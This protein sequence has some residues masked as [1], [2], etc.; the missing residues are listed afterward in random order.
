MERSAVRSLIG[1]YIAMAAV[2]AAGAVGAE[3]SDYGFGEL[4]RDPNAVLGGGPF[5]GA[6]S[7]VGVIL[8]F[9]TAALA[10]FAGRMTAKIGTDV[11]PFFLE[12]L[13]AYTVLL[14]LDDLFQLHEEVVP[15]LTGLGFRTMLLGYVILGAIIAF[16]YRRGFERSDL[17]ILLLVGVLFG[18]SVGSDPFLEGDSGYGKLIEDGSKLF[19]IVTWLVLVSQLGARR[20]RLWRLEQRS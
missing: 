19:G 18:V 15:A 6:L 20:L 17:A 8:W 10:V 7:N 5:V 1:A 16:V 11:P 4:T 12:T 13:A 14:G 9:C 3:A 2:L